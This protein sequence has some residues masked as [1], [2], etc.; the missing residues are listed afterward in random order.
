MKCMCIQK[1]PESQCK[2]SHF[3]KYPV[4]G[5]LDTRFLRH[6]CPFRKMDSDDQTIRFEISTPFN[7]STL[8]AHLRQLPGIHNHY[9]ESNTLVISF[10]VGIVDQQDLME[11]IQE[12]GYSATPLYTSNSSANH[13]NSSSLSQI[14]I[15]VEGMTCQV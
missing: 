13:S 5:N 8:N 6:L 1:S 3:Y 14:K 9:L 4:T 10:D 15:K 7:S 11:C 12:A 2:I